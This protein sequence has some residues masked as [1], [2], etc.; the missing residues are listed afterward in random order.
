MFNNGSVVSFAVKLRN[1][2]SF[3]QTLG[4]KNLAVVDYSFLG[5]FNH[6]VPLFRASFWSDKCKSVRQGCV[7]GRSIP[8][9]AYFHN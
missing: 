7:I 2:A 9:L 8:S 5:Y 1:R 6:P 4:G 3:D